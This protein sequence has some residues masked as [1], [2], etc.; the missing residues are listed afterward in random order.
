MI[1][2]VSGGVRQIFTRR[3]RGEPS[4]LYGIAAALSN[5]PPVSYLWRNQIHVRHRHSGDLA[6]LRPIEPRVLQAPH[7]LS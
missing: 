1:P 3:L 5:L 7:G 2:A 6:G 4:L